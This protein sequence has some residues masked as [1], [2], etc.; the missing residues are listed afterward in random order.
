MTIGAH[1]RRWPARLVI[2]LAT[3]TAIA[4]SLPNLSAPPAHARTG[5]A[6]TDEHGAAVSRTAAAL[7]LSVEL[8]FGRGSARDAWTL[9]EVTASPPV[10]LHGRVHARVSGPLGSTAGERAIEVAAGATQV[11]HLLLPP[12]DEVEVTYLDDGGDEVA[13]L[14]GW[15]PP[16]AGVFV[17]GLAAAPAL[18]SP[19]NSVGTD[20]PIRPVV[21]DP[22]VLALGPRALDGLDALLLS[23]GELEALQETERN[24]IAVAV[25]GGLDLIVTVTGGN[26]PLPLPWN[27]VAAV[28]GIGD[29]AAIDPTP[30]AWVAAPADFG[31]AG[32]DAVVASVRAG[33]GR[34][35]AVA[36]APGDG[37]AG[38]ARDLWASLFQLRTDVGTPLAVMDQGTDLTSMLFGGEIPLPGVLVFGMF[39]LVYIVLVGPIN[40]IVLRRLGR[41]ELA[42]ITV[43]ALTLVF[44]VVA[45][46]TAAGRAPVQTPVV[47]S[48]W[49][50]DGV[51]QEL[52]VASVQAPARGVVDVRLPG[53]RDGLAGQLW[54]STTSTVERDGG[55]TAVRVQLDTLAQGSVMAWGDPG[56]AAPLEVEIA[57]AGSRATVEVTNQTTATLE[58]VEVHLATSSTAVGVLAAG[59]STTVVV[60]DLEPTLARANPADQQQRMIRD[61]RGPAVSGGADAAGELL[62]WTM[63][64]GSPG[65]A[66]VTATS[67][68]DL[69][70]AVPDTPGSL[71]D[72]GSFVAVGTTLGPSGDPLLPHA[73]SRDLLRSEV[74]GAWRPVPLQIESS[75]EALLRFR[76]PG[77]ASQGTLLST[78]DVG[79]AVGQMVVPDVWS[80]GCFEVVEIAPD[81]TESDPEE[82]C[83]GSELPCPPT[84]ESCSEFDTTIEACFPD[85]S[86]TLSTW[87][88]DDE[89]GTAPG[90]GGGFEVF[91]HRTAAWVPLEDA[92]TDG[93]ATRDGSFVSPLGEVLVRVRAAGTVDIAQRGIALEGAA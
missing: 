39:A 24:T 7:G 40:G 32:D 27:P 47:R 79:G 57:F 22:A 85:G 28:A 42:W 25:A 76:L 15:N 46:T 64:D 58:D 70:L 89:P 60:D 73:V 38:A 88:P 43:P 37:G 66:W 72:R 16:E 51:G 91:D 13:L 44:T 80:G 69:G 11:F 12:S 23:A 2:A 93:K 33:R 71:D 3:V 17:G 10:P 34:V 41:R 54:G 8:G 48:T 74:Q 59:E 35:V 14:R 29:S 52:T 6:T 36:A 56:R 31:F 30:D 67:T 63:L 62:A 5:Q 83:G 21:V 68:S 26:G 50:L 75:G 18:P 4:I 84:T 82:R 87:L 19:L 77:P 81:G 45:V 90:D 65:I 53:H 1:W 49:W 20:R 9:I 92:F 55:T 86:C 78:L 61:G